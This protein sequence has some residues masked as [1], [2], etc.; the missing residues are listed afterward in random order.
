MRKL[1]LRK[2]FP[3]VFAREMER[4][5]DKWKRKRMSAARAARMRAV[6]KQRKSKES[7]EAIGA[8][9]GAIDE[10]RVASEGVIMT[11]ESSERAMETGEASE[12][13]IET[14]E[15]SRGAMATGETSGGDRGA[16]GA[17]GGVRETGE[18]SEE[19]GEVSGS[20]GETGGTSGG[21]GERGEGIGLSDIED[22]S[23]PSSDDDDTFDEEKAQTCFDDWM[24]SLPALDRKMLAVSLS[25]CFITRQK[26]KLTDA[27]K[28]AGS[29]V[30]VNEKTV[31][32]Y[33]KE[34]F[35]NH[36]RFLETKRGKYTRQCLLNNEDLRLEAS[37]WVHE[38]AHKKGGANMT[39]LSFCQWVN[40]TL[41]EQHD[42]PA[43][44]PRRISLRTATRWLH[45]L[46]FRPQSHKKGTYV[47]GHERE[48]V[49]K[50]RKTFLKYL[51]ELKTAHLP[52]PPCSDECPATPPPD[53]E[54]RKRLVM[55]YHDESIFNANE[56]QTWMWATEDTPVIQ[57][58]TK[59]AGV[60][61][62]D[63]VDQQRGYLRLTD[64][65]HAAVT[66]NIADFPK[67]A[68]ATLEYGADK[69]G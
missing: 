59:G 29:F 33:R 57:P 21:V 39:A 6:R 65:E 41:L 56:G 63:F 25:Q 68:R 62:S 36:G 44:L 10:T 20:V 14:G 48:D 1:H 34:Y 66:A 54:T 3:Y 50:A 32:K 8:S 45:H 61:V 5:S 27:V 67:T 19:T 9:S 12:G 55:L 16:G 49:I 35:S 23:A 31:R 46:G 11:G 37:I 15:A 17:S 53:A 28:K 51:H 4:E 30:G 69:E 2:L 42:L 24:V 22:E 40:D 43:N 64:E 26:M 58:K 47:D 13:A 60:M 7:E 38:N 18:S 52:P